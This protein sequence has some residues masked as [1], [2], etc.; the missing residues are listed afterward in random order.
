MRKD[1]LIAEG[2]GDATT[3]CRRIINSLNFTRWTMRS[4]EIGKSYNGQETSHPERS[5]N[6]KHRSQLPIYENDRYNRNRCE[7][8]CRY[9]FSATAAACQSF[10]SCHFT[11]LVQN[12]CRQHC[13]RARDCATQR[14]CD[15]A[16]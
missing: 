11:P 13:A 7:P 15:C 16:Q 4:S 3:E 8:N 1:L 9:D 14:S 10:V 6:I 2:R 5:E 12:T